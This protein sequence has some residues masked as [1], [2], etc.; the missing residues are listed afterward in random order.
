MRALL[1]LLAMRCAPCLCWA[2]ARARSCSHLMRPVCRNYSILIYI[3][4]TLWVGTWQEFYQ[5]SANDKIPITV[6]TV[7]YLLIVLY[8]L[9]LVILY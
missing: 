1:Q 3:C 9:T 6:L 7:L 2:L 4:T 5:Y 8:G